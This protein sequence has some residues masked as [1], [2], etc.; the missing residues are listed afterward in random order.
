VANQSL[1]PWI[2]QLTR[3][4][5]ADFR[6]GVSK[7]MAGAALELVDDGFARGIDPDGR[8][9][10]AS[11]TAAARAG[12]IMRDTGR[13]QRSFARDSSHDASE[14]RIGTKVR[15]AGV[16]KYGKKIK[17]RSK[18]YLKFRIGRGSSKRWVQTKEVEIPARPMIPGRTIPYR[19]ARKL[20][21]AARDFERNR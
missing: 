11:P 20:E 14:I 9:W 5:T 8:P 10:K 12:Q 15:Y 7:A 3:F 16:H 17:T 21:Q 13:L 4:T 2:R 6:S 19:W 1:E 18:P